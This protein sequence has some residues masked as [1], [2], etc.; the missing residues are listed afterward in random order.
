[1]SS[2]SSATL[3]MHSWKPIFTQSNQHYT[4][5]R[6]PSFK[7]VTM[8]KKVKRVMDYAAGSTHLSF[9]A[10]YTRITSTE[11]LWRILEHFRNIPQKYTDTHHL[12]PHLCNKNI[13][14]VP[15]KQSATLTMRSWN[16]I[17]TQSFKHCTKQ[18]IAFLHW[19]ALQTRKS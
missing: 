11:S 16:T 5:Y 14:L 12:L 19:N 2:R 9:L 17:F 18:D 8:I 10:H 13:L 3:I 6:I 7:C 1:M 4:V 15:Q